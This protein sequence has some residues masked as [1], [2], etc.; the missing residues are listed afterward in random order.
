[1]RDTQIADIT[2]FLR[3]EDLAEWV[4]PMEVRIQFNSFLCQD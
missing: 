2:Q 3:I 4:M 1:M